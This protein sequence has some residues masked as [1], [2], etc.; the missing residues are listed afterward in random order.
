MRL[1]FL[2][3]LCAECE[4]KKQGNDL[5]LHVRK[6]L[7]NLKTVVLRLNRLPH[8]NDTDEDAPKAWKFITRQRELQRVRLLHPSLVMQLE[9]FSGWAWEVLDTKVEQQFNN[10]RQVMQA[11]GN[12]VPSRRNKNNTND[13]KSAATFAHKQRWKNNVNTLSAAI[14]QE[15]ET[16][17]GWSWA[18]GASVGKATFKKPSARMLKKPSKHG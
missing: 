15:L 14:R 5:P 4:D 3:W 9:A 10:L 16:I 1:R 18:E 17:V 2:P 6:Q 12:K 8:K 7:L 11:N 13:E